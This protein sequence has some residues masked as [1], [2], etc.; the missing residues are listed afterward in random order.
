LNKEVIAFKKNLIIE[1][2]QKYFKE[3]G[4]VGTQIDKIAKELGMGVGTIYSFFGSKEGLFYSW[5]F[6]IMEKAYNEI[7]EQIAIEKNPLKQC[8]IFVE[9]KFMYYEKNKS[10]F[11]DFLQSQ[12]AIQGTNKGAENPMKKVYK[13]LAISIKNFTDNENI[14]NKFIENSY[15]L[16]YLLDKIVDSYIDCYAQENKEIN[17]MTKTKEVMEMFLNAIGMRDYEY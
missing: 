12:Y 5:L 13:L 10:V 4:F 17:L 16:A 14:K 11:R 2:A 6:S 15:H 1:T 3:F 9:Y 7:K 8:E